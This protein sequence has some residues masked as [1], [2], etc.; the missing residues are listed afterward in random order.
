MNARS[1]THRWHSSCLCGSFTQLSEVRSVCWIWRGTLVRAHRTK[2]S[3]R[4]WRKVYKK[5]FA[6]GPLCLLGWV[7]IK[8]I[9]QSFQ[10]CKQNSIHHQ[11]W[12]GRINLRHDFLKTSA[13]KNKIICIARYQQEWVKKTLWITWFFK[14]LIWLNVY[15]K[16][17]V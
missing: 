11:Y 4:K 8:C 10:H 14:W 6:W 15:M 2:K 7:A 12:G 3:K 17:T 9:F 5:V 1:I 16:Y 13:H